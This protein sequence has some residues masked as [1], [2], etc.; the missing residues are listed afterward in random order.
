MS[1]HDFLVWIPAPLAAFAALA[2]ALDLGD[3]GGAPGRRGRLLVGATVAVL[4][5]TAFTGLGARRRLP[6]SV[7]GS[8][9]APWDVHANLAV[10]LLVPALVLG[11]FRIRAVGAAWRDKPGRLVLLDL[12]LLLLVSVIVATGLRIP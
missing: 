4:L 8:P 6:A 10:V 7:P 1:F 5:V 12:G 3:S 11:F 2:D 9:M